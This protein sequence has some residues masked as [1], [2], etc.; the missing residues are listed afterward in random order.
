[1]KTLL[2]THLRINSRLQLIFSLCVLALST[3]PCLG[4][5]ENASSTSLNISPTIGSISFVDNRFSYA[6]PDRA[7]VY[8]FSIGQEIGLPKNEK[9]GFF[10]EIRFTYFNGKT[11]YDY[12]D[13]Y[14]S[15]TQGLKTRNIA[16]L[17]INSYSLNLDIGYQ[18]GLFQFYVPIGIGFWNY[19]TTK[20]EIFTLMLND[21]NALMEYEVFQFETDLNLEN[22]FPFQLGAGV[23]LL[24]PWINTS[25]NLEYIYP[26]DGKNKLTEDH[27]SPVSASGNTLYG[28]EGTID[29]YPTNGIVLLS[30]SYRIPIGA[31]VK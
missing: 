18:V 23:S 20:D 1:M 15:T 24:L 19:K 21:P 13:W 29:R 8:G 31:K 4:Q 12:Q 14:F 27:F 30:L 7:L 16:E 5:S 11:D 25:V 6:K 17:K 26:I 28:Y 9:S 10:A 3:A 22:H 2:P